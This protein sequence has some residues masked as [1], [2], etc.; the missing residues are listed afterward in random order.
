MT[1]GGEDATFV[2]AGIDQ[3][4]EW[5]ELPGVRRDVVLMTQLLK[6]LG[7]EERHPTWTPTSSVQDL[8]NGFDRWRHERA[9]RSVIYW[10]GHAG[11][12]AGARFFLLLKASPLRRMGLDA[13]ERLKGR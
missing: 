6:D 4:D 8:Q 1:L 10:A 5:P 7:F 13:G 2:V 11:A 12:K 3:Y 9:S